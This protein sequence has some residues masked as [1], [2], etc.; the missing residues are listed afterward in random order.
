M[1]RKADIVFI[2]LVYRNYEDLYDLK[3]SIELHVK[4]AYEIVVVEAYYDNQTSEYVKDCALKLGC[5][6]ICVKN[7]GYGYGN[8]KGFE[9]VENNFLCQYICV[10]NPDI[11][12]QSD[13]S[14]ELLK[15]GLEC[16]APDIITRKGKKQNP[17]WPYE[18]SLIEKLIYYG[19]K[20]KNRL[21]IYSGV[22][23]NKLYRMYWRMVARKY[24]KYNIYACHGSFYIMQTTFVKKNHFKYDENMFLFYE[25]AYHAHFLKKHQAHIC[26]M[27]DIKILHKEDGSMNIANIEEMPYLQHSYLY[28]YEKYRMR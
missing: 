10:C 9:Y 19:Y 25:E 3:R 11:M 5:H 20:K 15:S 4:A 13:I 28:Y 8:N 21:V 7:G 14:V 16:I 24:A 27:R 6:Y 17:Y 2:T 18:S 26:F 23:I 12:I 22:V 1:K